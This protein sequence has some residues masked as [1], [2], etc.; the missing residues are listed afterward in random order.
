MLNI[1]AFH[2]PPS[3]DDGEALRQTVAGAGYGGRIIISL[4][5]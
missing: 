2:Y 3:S 1:A 4:N 5:H